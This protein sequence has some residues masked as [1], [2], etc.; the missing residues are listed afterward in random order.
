SGRTQQGRR[1]ALV[2]PGSEGTGL[3]A[4]GQQ[5]RDKGETD[6]ETASQLAA[7][8]CLLI[9][10]LGHPLTQVH[11]VGSHEGTSTGEDPLCYYMLCATRLGGALGQAPPCAG[12]ALARLR[13]HRPAPSACQA[14]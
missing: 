3:A 13:C 7:R 2:G 4:Q 9:D 14:L 8:A 5:T 1:A 12:S 11:G 10:R 6:A